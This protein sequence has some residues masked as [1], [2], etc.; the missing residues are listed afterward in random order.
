MKKLFVVI[1]LLFSLVGKAQYEP[2]QN[3][4]EYQ[5]M[6]DLTNIVDDQIE[7]EIIVP[8]I[9]EETAVYNMPV[10]V[11]GTYKIY[12]FGRFLNRFTAIG[13]RGDTLEVES[14]NENQWKINNARDLYKISYW[15][16]DTYD[17]KG[18][19]IFAPAGTGISEDVFMLNNFGF[20]GY[21]EGMK[22]VD[23]DF[24]IKKPEGFVGSTSLPIV[25]LTD[26]LDS[27]HA[28][29]YFQLH[30]CPML[31]SKPDTASVNVSGVEITVAVYSPEGN[32]NAKEIMDELEPIF[33]AAAE[34]LG[35]DLPAELYTVLIYGMSMKDMMM[36]VGALEH[37]TSTVVNIPDISNNYMK[38]VAGEGGMTQL[39]RDIVSHEFFHI[40]TPLNIHSE[41]I[42]DF[43]F[44][45]PTMSQHLWLYEGVTEYNSNISQVRYGIL[46][47]DE[48]MK[49]MRDKMKNSH[50]FNE[51]IPFTVSSKF[52]L[53]YF[54]KEYLNV[55]EKGA[56][57]GMCLDLTLLSE[58]DGDYGLPDLLMDLRTTYGV[59]TFFVD[60]ELFD[61]IYDVTES[62]RVREF[63]ARHVEGAEALPYESLLEEVGYSYEKEVRAKTI[64]DGGLEFALKNDNIIVSKY[65]KNDN[66]IKELG[67]VRGDIILS[68]NGMKVSE[69]NFVDLMS[70]FTAN[71]EAGSE[72][73]LEVKRK[74]G[75]KYQKKKLKS[76][77]QYY[78]T[79]SRDVLKKL[80]SPTKNQE[81][82]KLN[83]LKD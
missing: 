19:S 74:L 57:I 27:Y 6:M 75:Q 59:D 48:F 15:A 70:D 83:W 79:V 4:S 62:D 56:L 1:I 42:A 60:N 67:I 45:N 53:S 64:S 46:T 9:H 31:Y 38:M 52:A 25:E 65:R 66:F 28:D 78:E 29:H 11:P 49:N 17:G 21:L 81:N 50:S 7:I 20:I 44:M 37:H 34:Y 23:F 5:V 24:H 41:Q 69:E 35:G 80:D 40:V 39:L 51:S 61:I 26:T 82:M 12:N 55:Y 54:S 58:S 72:V 71:A 47:E 8:L 73:E 14:L 36:G 3:E 16:D 32:L 43:D 33:H 63:F 2:I 76:T 77:V 18:K 68:F 30:D 22:D 10:M 13:S